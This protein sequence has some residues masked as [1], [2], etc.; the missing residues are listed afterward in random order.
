MD[1]WESDPH[2]RLEPDR[3]KTIRA[4]WM[5]FMPAGGVLGASTSGNSVFSPETLALPFLTKRRRAPGDRS[6]GDTL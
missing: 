2:P 5:V 6:C 3:K 1:L 4:G